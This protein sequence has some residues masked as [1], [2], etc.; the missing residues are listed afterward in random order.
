MPRWLPLLA[1]LAAAAAPVGAGS[2]QTAGEDGA[3]VIPYLSGGAGV[4]LDGDGR[5][6]TSDGAPR[7]PGIHL[8]PAPTPVPPPAAH[9]ALRL[10]LFE[11]DK[12]I[13]E[14]LTGEAFERTRS[15]LIKNVNLLIKTK[16]AELGFD[17]KERFGRNRRLPQIPC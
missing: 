9:F 15:F 2:A 14:G 17:F 16:Q 8:Q 11:L 13:R 1:L 5:P 6:V 10:A 3:T 7:T 4:F 12:L